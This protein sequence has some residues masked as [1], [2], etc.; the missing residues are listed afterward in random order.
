MQGQERIAYLFLG[1]RRHLIGP[2]FLD[3]SRPLY[4]SAGHYPLGPIATEHWVPFIRE[5]FEKAGKEITSE[6]IEKLCALTEGHP[7]YTQHLAH[8]LWERTAEGTS[9]TDEGLEEAVDTLLRRESYAFTTRWETL[10]RNQ[11]R[12]LR[13]LAGAPAGATPFS[14]DFV[15]T[16]RLGSASNAQRAAESLLKLDLID[17]DNGTF[18]ITDRFLRL[19]IG[20]LP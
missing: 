19:W 14:A 15:R 5:N 2:M 11:Q 3:G 10:T 6:L 9:V 7:F 20:R 16:W 1:S 17:R 8:A 12:F 4:R 18:V 13:G